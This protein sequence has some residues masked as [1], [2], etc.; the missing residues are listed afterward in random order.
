MS[1]TVPQFLL[2]KFLATDTDAVDQSFLVP[3]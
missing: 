1:K 3:N 2:V